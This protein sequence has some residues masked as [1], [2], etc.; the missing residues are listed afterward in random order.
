MLSLG[1]RHLVECILGERWYNVAQ[2]LE[3]NKIKLPDANNDT[4]FY[5]ISGKRTQGKIGNTNKQLSKNE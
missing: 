2:R 3:I 4:Q 5:S 1:A